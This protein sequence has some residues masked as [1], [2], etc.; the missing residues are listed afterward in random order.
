[1][2]E[3]SKNRGLVYV[4]AAC[5]K[6]NTD[7]CFRLEKF[8]IQGLSNCLSPYELKIVFNTVVLYKIMV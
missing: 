1:M 3:L 6:I 7:V 8:L 4:E 5:W 2:C